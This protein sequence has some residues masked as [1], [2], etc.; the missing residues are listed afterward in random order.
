MPTALRVLVAIL[1]F[2]VIS[3]F[4]AIIQGTVRDTSGQPIAGVTV[5]VASTGQPAMIVVTDQ[6]GHYEARVTSGAHQLSFRR[7]NFAGVRRT[8]PIAK[9]GGLRDA[10]LDAA[11]G[12]AAEQDIRAFRENEEGEGFIARDLFGLAPQAATKSAA[13]EVIGR[14]GRLPRREKVAA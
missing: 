6:N 13:R 10:A 9:R 5:D 8:H 1:P 14:P 3:A 4:G 7:I 12:D 2:A 11:D